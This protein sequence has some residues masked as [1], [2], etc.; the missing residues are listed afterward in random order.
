MNI[1]NFESTGRWGWKISVPSSNQRRPNTKV[2]DHVNHT[3]VSHP[4]EQG[5]QYSE[6][7]IPI[8]TSENLMFLFVS[9]GDNSRFVEGDEMNAVFD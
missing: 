4:I 5:Q 7:V 2:V 9:S 3:P 8:T 1:I 6:Q